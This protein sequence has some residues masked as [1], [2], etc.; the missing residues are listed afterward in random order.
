MQTNCK[1]DWYAIGYWLF[2]IALCVGMAIAYHLTGS[3]LVFLA[4]FVVICVTAHLAVRHEA[5]E[6]QARVAALASRKKV[7]NA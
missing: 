7:P 5:R 3:W 6:R 4:G 2:I 1:F